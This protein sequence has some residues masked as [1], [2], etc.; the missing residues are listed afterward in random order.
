MQVFEDQSS[1][2][3]YPSVRSGVLATVSHGVPGILFGMLLS[4]FIFEHNQFNAMWDALPVIIGLILFLTGGIWLLW[5]VVNPRC[6]A[7]RF[8][9]QKFLAG[10]MGVGGIA[11]YLGF[12]CFFH[13]TNIDN[14]K[15]CLG[16][17]NDGKPIG[18]KE[19]AMNGDKDNP[20]YTALWSKCND[21]YSFTTP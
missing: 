17:G 6:S 5:L 11:M 20:P 8:N 3:K 4:A 9:A 12:W 7:E 19:T 18:M 16:R 10:V 2:E 21:G 14:T 1:V 13:N 15:S